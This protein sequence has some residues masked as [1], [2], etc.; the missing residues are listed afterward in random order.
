[1][2]F[3]FTAGSVRNRCGTGEQRA[4]S[5]ASGGG[6]GEPGREPPQAQAGSRRSEGAAGS[7]A[8]SQGRRAGS[9]S[10]PAAP[11][12]RAFAAGLRRP[13]C[14]RALRWKGFDLEI[15]AESNRWQAR[16]FYNSKRLVY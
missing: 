6:G 3:L 9:A 10:A 5:G 15:E 11:L 8:G 2:P 14:T 4:G 13:V 1:M 7:P 16:A 12:L